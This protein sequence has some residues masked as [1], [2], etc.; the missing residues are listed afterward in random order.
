MDRNRKL[1]TFFRESNLNNLKLRNDE[2]T[3]Y[4]FTKVKLASLIV[5]TLDT[6]I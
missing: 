2:A 3:R 6:L 5:H 4:L 1:S